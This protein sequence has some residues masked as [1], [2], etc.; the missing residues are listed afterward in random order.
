MLACLPSYL[1]DA[2]T[3]K[4][5]VLSSFF[6]LFIVVSC[7]FEEYLFKSTPGF[8]FHTTVA[9]VELVTFALGALAR[10]AHRKELYTPLKAPILS[11]I[12]VAV[13]LALAQSI[14][15]IAI[16]YT[17]Y[18]TATIL[19]SGKLIPT[20]LLSVVWLRRKHSK[21]EWTAA[22]LLVTSS[23]LMA[24]GERALEPDFNEFG[25]LLGIVFL[26]LSALQGNMQDRILRDHGA[27]VDELMLYSNAFG[28]I[29]AFAGIASSGELVAASKFF[30]GNLTATGVL[31][32][33]SLTFYAGAMCYTHVIRLYGVAAATAVGTARKTITVLLSFA[34]VPKPWHFNYSF[35]LIAFVAADALYVRQKMLKGASSSSSTT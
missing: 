9:F 23:A 4:F 32:V 27:T 34:V 18:V 19:R 20:L 30:A 28:A 25:I 33:R 6:L 17:N 5:I 24:L 13:T 3:R 35:G 29:L 26:F 12:G 10:L 22:V 11:H 8:A 21:L 1:R 31:L 15:K 7:V 16:K 2:D 14:G